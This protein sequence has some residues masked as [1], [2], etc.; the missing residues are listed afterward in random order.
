MIAMKTIKIIVV[1][2]KHLRWV[3]ILNLKPIINQWIW[4]TNQTIQKCVDKQTKI[5][6]VKPINIMFL[7]VS[8]N[9]TI[10]KLGLSKRKDNFFCQL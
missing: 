1:S 3:I 10:K 9:D 6:N 7:S 8:K 2:V 5:I 4:K